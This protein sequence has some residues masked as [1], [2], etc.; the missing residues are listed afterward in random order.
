M[1]R[2]A[3]KNIVAAGLA[4]KC[5]IQVSYALGK[6]HPISLTVDTF[7]TEKLDRKKIEDVVK[8]VF[9]FRPAAILRNLDLRKPIYRKTACY[10]HF[11][12]NDKDFTWE[13]TDKAVILKELAGL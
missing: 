12:R 10:G 7:G 5:E 4:E 9:D 11:G 6:A 2:Y 1:A 8:E 13:K 3:A